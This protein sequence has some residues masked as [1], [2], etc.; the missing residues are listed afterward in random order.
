MSRFLALL[1]LTLVLL[2]GVYR[3][4]NRA[5]IPSDI[6]RKPYLQQV[7]GDS[8]L[9]CWRKVPSET[10]EA[11]VQWR[12]QGSESW[13]N[14]EEVNREGEGDQPVNHWARLNHL[15]THTP[16]EYLVKEGEKVLGRGNFLSA[17]TTGSPDPLRVWVLG[18]SGTGKR[19][20]YQ[21][22]QAMVAHTSSPET[23][24]KI[25][26]MLHVGDM[27]Y[28]HGKEVEFTGRFFRPYSSMLANLPCWPAIG[29]HEVK[30]STSETQSGPYFDAYVLPTHGE[31]GGEA[32]NSEAYYSFNN[33][34]VHFIS[35][36]SSGAK[37]TPDS[38]MV[39][40]LQEDLASHDRE[41]CIAFFHHPPYSMGTHTSQTARDSHG[42][43]VAMREI[44]IPLLEAAGTDL[45]LAGHSHGYERSAL[46]RGVF[47]YGE[48]PDFVVPD[49]STLLADGKILGENEDHYEVAKGQGSLYVVVGHGGA[50][51]EIRG[52]HPVMDRNDDQHGSLLLTIDQS[53]LLLENVV[54]GNKVQDRVTLRRPSP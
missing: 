6:P 33:G 29:N 7:H 42:R 3:L 37:I 19:R 13:N 45:I 35:L 30:S 14:A 21:V 16:I 40:W 24:G 46:I 17:Q 11:V 9:V 39:Q 10:D 43:L 31:C 28:S 22:L 2:A 54:I 52:K 25:D 12:K 23:G 34:P 8:A 27:A 41:W 15:P 53:S 49:R 26:L 4:D 20:Q 47:G 32:S 18:D 38:P 36:D 5:F 48:S 1:F 51:V 44:I 50:G